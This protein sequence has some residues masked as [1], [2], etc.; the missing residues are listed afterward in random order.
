MISYLWRCVDGS[1]EN[2]VILDYLKHTPINSDDKIRLYDPI[3]AISLNCQSSIP[4]KFLQMAHTEPSDRKALIGSESKDKKVDFL[5]VCQVIKESLK[6][7]TIKIF[8][9]EQIFG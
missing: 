5:V 4:K 6:N 3:L 7:F 1:Q 8:L 9:K 2:E